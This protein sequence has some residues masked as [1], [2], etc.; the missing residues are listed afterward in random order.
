[1]SGCR[2]TTV[3]YAVVS[4]RRLSKVNAWTSMPLAACVFCPAVTTVSP[5]MTDTEGAGSAAA[6]TAAGDIR[7]KTSIAAAI[8][9]DVVRFIRRAHAAQ[10]SEGRGT[11]PAMAQARAVVA[12]HPPVH[13][14]IDGR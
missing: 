10:W 8:T 13:R 9:V 14:P 2:S 11:E 1:M 7:A 6:G 5:F 3:P 4:P 12:A